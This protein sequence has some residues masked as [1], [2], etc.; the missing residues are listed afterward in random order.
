M[1]EVADVSPVVFVALV[2]LHR[3][4]EAFAHDLEPD[5]GDLVGGHFGFG[6]QRMEAG[7]EPMEGDLAHHRVQPVLDL[8][9][10]KRAAVG[11][12]R[13]RQQ[14]FEHQAFA[15]DGG[16]LGQGQG[17]VGQ[18]SAERGG[19]GLVHSVAQLMG[20]GQHVA[21]LAHIV[22]EDVGVGVGTDRVG[23]GARRLAAPGPCIDPGVVE[24]GAGMVGEDGGQAFEGVQHHPLGVVPAVHL[25]L[26]LIEGSVAIPVVQR[27]LTHQLGLEG[28]VAVRQ[29]RIGL[30]HRLFHGRDRGGIDLIGQV[31]RGGRAVE[32]APAILDR[33]FHR[34]RIQGQA[35]H[36]RIGLQRLGQALGRGFAL[37]GVGV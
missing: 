20:Q 15:E 8:A 18:Q 4:A 14:P 21:P 22:E 36:R 32:L 34:H 16:G 11:G 29:A 35:E 26:G 19:Q 37:F 9:R 24:E 12:G 1:D 23:I 6:A 2:Q 13:F 10:E 31:T 28:V 30:D 33:L 7:F 5:F 25:R 27:L 3:R 17:G